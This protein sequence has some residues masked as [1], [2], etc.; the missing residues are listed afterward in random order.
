MIDAIA[1]K[2]P[3][4]TQWVHRPKKHGNWR[5]VDNRLKMWTV[6][7]TWERVFTDLV[8]QGDAD[9]DVGWAVL[10]DSTIVRAHQHAAGARKKGTPA[11]CRTTTPSAGPAVDSPRRSPL[12]ADDRCRPL[13]FYLT[14]GQ[15]GAASAF[16]VAV[17]PSCERHAGALKRPGMPPSKR[18][19]ES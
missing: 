10:V 8:A 5:G 12:A 15:A 16:S 11:V 17:I 2:F 1:Y 18:A 19:M 9:E 6:D 14:A 4:G 7:G 3:T 13:A